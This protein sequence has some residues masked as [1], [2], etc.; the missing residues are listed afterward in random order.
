MNKFILALVALVVLLF[1]ILVVAPG[2]IPVGAYKGRIEAAASEALGRKVAIGDGLR[3][4]I[5]PQ[6]AFRVEGLEIANEEGFAAP[7]LARVKAAEIGVKLIPLL[8]KSVV[9]DHFILTEPEIN[10]AR[11]ADGRV[12]WNIAGG[13]K[14]SAGAGGGEVKDLR[15]GDVRIIDGKATYADAQGGKNYE[16]SDIDLAIRLDSLQEPLEANGTLVF[17]GA[18]AKVDLVLTSL[19]A[20]MRREDANLKLDLTLGA[21]KAGADVVVKTKDALSYSGPASLSAP[22]L[23]A[24]AAHLGAPIPETPGFEKLAVDGMAAGD[25]NGVK[26]SNA[27][28]KFDAIDAT[29]ELALDWA[30]ARPKASGAVEAGALDLRPYLPPPAESAQGFPAW[31]EDKIDFS[32]LKNIDAD[33][34]IGA[35]KI[36]LNE[37]EFGESRLHLV[38]ENGRMTADIPELGLYGGGGSGRLVVDARPATPTIAGAFD[39]ASVKAEPFALALMRTDRLLGLGGLKFDFTASGS[40]QAAIMRTLDG[41]GG[42]DV[43]EGALKGVNLTKLAK[44]VGEIQKGGLNPAAIASAVTAAQAPTERTDFSELL[45]QFTVRNGLVSAP[46]ISLTAPFLAMTGTG[47][48]NLP[49]QTLD[50]RLS[51]RA[52]TTMSGEDGAS[53]A[54]P[55]RVTGTFSQ[56]KM[57]VDLESLLKG[58]AEQSVKSIIGGFG[59]KEG[60]A[61]G[62][63]KEGVGLKI[64]EGALGGAKAPADKTQN[65]AAGEAEQKPTLKEEIAAEAINQL[66]GKKKQPAESAEPAGDEPPPE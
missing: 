31:S 10:L 48:V 26:L 56:P 4:K 20:M 6:T 58:R 38:I 51:P 57:A 61:D 52:R 45:S 36:F 53:L 1:A 12:N 21:A 54:I 29:G 16:A 44:A 63:A 3:L 22:D 46:T 34:N 30:G 2:F 19:D 47:S 23:R 40:S 25:A 35:E 33:L 9:I 37:L 28:I 15:L 64:L 41:S 43:S 5:I 65:P 7:Y 27:T 55:L 13:G 14:E 42:F 32:G 11:A 66:F 50:L 17:D 18:P 49:G 60:A 62:A 59:K 39:V 24:F 8:S